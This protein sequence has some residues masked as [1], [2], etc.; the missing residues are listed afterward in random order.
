MKYFR[1]SRFLAFDST[2]HTCNG[3]GN[4]FHWDIIVIALFAHLIDYK[5]WFFLLIRF[6]NTFLHKFQQICEFCFNI[7]VEFLQKNFHISTWV[8]LGPY[9]AFCVQGPEPNSQCRWDRL[10]RCW[11]HIS[12]CKGI[13]NLKFVLKLAGSPNWETLTLF[14][15]FLL[16]AT[17]AFTMTLIKTI[18]KFLNMIGYHQP[19]LSINRIF[20]WSCL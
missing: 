7:W 2:G 10:D 4:L 14:I 20:Y 17:S 19:D 8:H 1:Q 11:K 18:T 3:G 16:Y 5:Q 6:H 13:T 12:S 9:N 15:G